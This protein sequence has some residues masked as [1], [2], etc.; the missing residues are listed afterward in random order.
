MT[1]F[2]DANAIAAPLIAETYQLERA[3]ERHKAA[4]VACSSSDA[5]HVYP[6]TGAKTGRGFYCHSCGQ[7]FS[8]VDL[9]M[10]LHACDSI[11]AARDIAARFGIPVEDG[12]EAYQKPAKSIRT[13]QPTQTPVLS[14]Q[15]PYARI[16]DALELGSQAR[17]YLAGRGISPSCAHWMG[18]R[19]V[20]THADLA[21]VYE[22]TSQEEQL[23]YGLVR[24]DNDRARRV[25]WDVPFLV[26]PYLEWCQPCDAEHGPEQITLL[27]FAPFG[28]YREAYPKLK[29]LS[30]YG[31]RPDEPYCAWQVE[32]AL[33]SG[34]LAVTEGELNALSL[35]TL[36][37]P[38]VAT[39]GAQGW[40]SSWAPRLSSL[41][42][43]LLFA[44]GDKAGQ[45]WAQQITQ[46]LAAVTGYYEAQRLCVHVHL[47]P[48]QDV[49]DMLK[50]GRLAALVDEVRCD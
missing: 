28:A 2:D 15:S 45:S 4:C 6:D 1:I 29:Y 34:A 8:N 35:H 26:L 12:H 24:M 13:L 25:V 42:R 16:W 23:R 44:D 38:A 43:V 41:K 20:E 37:M 33:D 11:T 31:R 21:A 22:L 5:L 10:A 27:R 48:G 18:V 32:G 50:A 3:R 7:G 19:S 36:G 30:P 47:P 9:V 17:A 14:P 46:D 40:R 39:A 49:N